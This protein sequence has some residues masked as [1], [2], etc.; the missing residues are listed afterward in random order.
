MPVLSLSAAFVAQVIGCPPEGKNTIYFDQEI[1]GFVLEHRSSGGATFYFRYRDAE[2]KVRLCRIGKVTEISTTNARAAA[3][4]M[5][6][7]LADG[8]DPKSERQA[9]MAAPI[10]KTFVRERYMPYAVARKRSWKTDESLLRLHILPVFGTFCMSFVGRSQVLEF[11]HAMLHKGYAPGT[12]NRALMLLKFIFNC[13]VRWEML[14][15]ARN[16]CCNIELFKDNGARERY[17]TLQEARNLLLELKR[18]P[19]KQVANV[20]RL[21]LYTG[22]RKREVLDARWENIDLEKG[23]L[24]VPVAKSGR[25]RY[26]RLSNIAI[27]L[28]Q[29]LTRDPDI[30]WLFYN[31]RTGKPPVSIFGAWDS[32]RRRV[33]LADLRLHD[34][35]HSFASFLVNSGGS[36]YEVQK[37]LGHYDPKVTMRYAHLSEDTLKSA[38]NALAEGLTEISSE[39]Q[40]EYTKGQYQLS[41]QRAG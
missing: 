34:L 27:K 21:L 15:A 4:R 28:I 8:G 26:V 14:P 35:R 1:K 38:V 30:P 31:P 22:A 5:H 10:F 40:H 37:L 29:G 12:C 6:R 18:N 33:G 41:R 17:L 11:Q 9:R 23:I 16:P 24:T 20:I 32:I 39:V 19:N 2:A 7:T 36:L 3:H 25:P 13:A